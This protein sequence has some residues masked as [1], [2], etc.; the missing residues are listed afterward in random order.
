M[1]SPT[2]EQLEK[3]WP[4]ADVDGYGMPRPTWLRWRQTG[5]GGSDAAKALGLSPYGT[6]VTIYFEKIDEPDEDAGDEVQSIGL[7]MENV[8]AELFVKET[9]HKVFNPAPA[10]RSKTHPF[11][12]AT[13]DR[14]VAVYDE[15]HDEYHLAVL[16][17]KNVDI[18]KAED[19]KDGPPL[20]ARVQLQHYLFVTGLQFGFIMAL[21]GGNRPVLFRIERD[22]EL[23]VSIIARCEALWTMVQLRRCPDIDGSE[24]TR[25]AVRAHFPEVLTDK[26]EVPEEFRSLMRQRAAAK[27]DVKDAERRVNEAE[28]AM[29]LMLGDAA[30]ATIGG[31]TVMTYNEVRK[32]SYVVKAQHHRSWHMKKG[33][34]E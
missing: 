27:L 18:S 14:F 17:E 9:G 20:Y 29:L 21:I 3:F 30:E 32:E 12:L 33:A 11:M 4:A 31:V 25:E 22:E 19:W 10:L 1:T 5:M 26:R 13:P 2:P 28:T 7:L 15:L 34:L 23:I 16:E 24:M 8:I 6:P